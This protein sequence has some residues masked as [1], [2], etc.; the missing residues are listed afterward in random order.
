MNELMKQLWKNIKIL[1]IKDNIIYVG[2]TINRSKYL[3]YAKK[4]DEK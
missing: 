1:E 3:E 2:T 4:T